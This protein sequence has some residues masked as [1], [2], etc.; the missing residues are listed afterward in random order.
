[1]SIGTN[2][3]IGTNPKMIKPTLE[4]LFKGDW[5]KGGIPENWDGKSA[6]RIVEAILNLN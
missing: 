5:K 2:E 6:E 1:M 4:K 3:L